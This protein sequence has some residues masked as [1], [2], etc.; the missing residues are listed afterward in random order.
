MPILPQA[1]NYI[2]MIRNK[3]E[4]SKADINKNQ[5]ALKSGRLTSEV[6]LRKVG[7][8]IYKKDKI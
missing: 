6:D 3:Y 1:T 7:I 2:R 5:L 4:T 8:I